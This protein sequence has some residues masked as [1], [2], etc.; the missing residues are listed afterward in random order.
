MSGAILVAYMLLRFAQEL[1]EH[2]LG[3]LNRNYYS[4]QKRQHEAARLLNMT[5]DDMRRTLRYTDD[6]YHFGVISS[7]V[8]FVVG[9]GFLLAGGLGVVEQLAKSTA[10]S[11]GGGGPVLTGLAFFGIF[12]LISGIFGLPFSLYSTFVIEQ[13]HG[14]NRQT[15]KGFVIDLIK[16]TLLG[17]ILGGGLLAA[18]LAVMESMGNTWWLYA[19]GV[20]TLFSLVMV[21]A[22]PT[23]LAPLF[24]KFR[25]LEAGELK[26]G[27][28]ALANKVGFM[29]DGVFIM[30]ASKRSSH[31][32]AYFTGIHKKK[33][34]VI[35]DTL[36]EALTPQETVAV[37]AHELGHFKLH[38]VRWG[39]IRS[40][41]TSLVMFA[42]IGL[43]LPKQAFYEAFFL[44][45]V[46][47]YGGL[48][49]F[50]MWFG[51]LQFLMQ[52]LETWLSRRNEFAADAFA[53]QQASDRK[54]LGHA[55]IKLRDRNHAMPLTHP[56]Y[57]AMYYSH[58][59]LLERLRVMG[60][61]G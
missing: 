23:F 28:D 6:K 39:L 29:T 48:A 4:D 43:F 61:I 14:F 53:L 8:K 17:I 59:P 35:F 41:A 30:D 52:P 3:R 19:W 20:L 45:G 32:N 54:A 22:Y 49:V 5:E 2:R 13:R 27:I 60:Y 16:G 50:S 7:W 38:H 31:G 33:R 47:A 25:P 36:L 1:I 57:S 21:W 10:A 12:A 34:I 51:L 56:T 42:L 46:S 40:V 9:M 11:W 55:L 15:P 18:I 44:D 58:P 26:N 37:L 24:N